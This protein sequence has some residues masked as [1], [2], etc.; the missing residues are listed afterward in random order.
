MKIRVIEG[1]CSGQARCAAAAPEIFVL[2]EDGYLDIPE[3]HIASEREALARR[4]ARACP[5]RA[6][7]VI[8]DK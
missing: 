4:G 1:K 2:N 8:E 6:I 7:E 5:E 3:V